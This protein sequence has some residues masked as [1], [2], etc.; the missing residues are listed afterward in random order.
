MSSFDERTPGTIK[1]EEELA[2]VSQ[3]SNHAEE[4]KLQFVIL[5]AMRRKRVEEPNALPTDRANE[6]TTHAAVI[7]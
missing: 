5:R 2:R 6:H 1:N 4:Y 7:M 3:E